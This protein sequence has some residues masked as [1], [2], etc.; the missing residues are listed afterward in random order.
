MISWRSSWFLAIAWC[1]PLCSAVLDDQESATA[2][3][4]AEDDQCT[5]ASSCALSA[6][7]VDSRRLASAEAIGTKARQSLIGYQ[8]PGVALKSMS[9]VGSGPNP[10]TSDCLTRAIN[11]S[12][13]HA[14]MATSAFG[15]GGGGAM[16]RTRS[17]V[18]A[19]ALDKSEVDLEQPIY[20]ELNMTSKSHSWD[21]PATIW[22]SGLTEM[23][24]N[25]LKFKTKAAGE[26]P[27]SYCLMHE[28][29]SAETPGSSAS[30]P[31]CGWAPESSE[32]SLALGDSTKVSLD[33]SALVKASFR[34]FKIWVGPQHLKK[35]GMWQT[36][37]YKITSWEFTW[38]PVSGT[39]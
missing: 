9:F 17:L 31:P 35:S 39:S 1:Q 30:K 14:A 8:G 28:P 22:V 27:P 7:Q 26:C 25:A 15:A 21:Q 38:V 33:V 3:L 10:M 36:R 2:K 19:N 11:Q 4:I 6:L 18:I 24:P 34:A 23:V 13:Q 20:L 12:S 37:R 5:H 16:W 29:A 32:V